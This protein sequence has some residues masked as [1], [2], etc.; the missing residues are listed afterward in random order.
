[1]PLIHKNRCL[2]DLTVH[3]TYLPSVLT[4]EQSTDMVDANES[5]GAFLEESE[6]E[7]PGK[8]TAAEEMRVGDSEDEEDTQEDVGALS[9]D[10]EDFVIGKKRPI[11]RGRPRGKKIQ[12][13]STFPEVQPH[14]QQ[15][16]V[17]GIH[18]FFA[19]YSVCESTM[20]RT[21]IV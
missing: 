16:H 2:P 15:V 3:G 6:S 17:R 9:T 21:T 5:E 4:A 14:V 13:T 20:Q 8:E 18:M 7:N 12:H 1:M 11:S 10:D 19:K